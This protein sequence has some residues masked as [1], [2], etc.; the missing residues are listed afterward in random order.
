MDAHDSRADKNTTV[1]IIGA[2]LVDTGNGGRLYRCLE[3]L[4]GL[5]EAEVYL[6]GPELQFEGDQC[7]KGRLEEY[8]A[9]REGRYPDVA[10]IFQPGFEEH[11]Q[12]LESGDI[13]TLL[14][15]G[16]RVIGSS[17]SE[18]EYLRDRLMARAYGYELSPASDNPYALDP[19][20]TGLHWGDRMWHFQGKT[21]TD[22]FTPDLQL[23]EDVRRLSRMVAHSRLHGSGHQPAN[24]G[25]RFEA[26]DGKGGHRLMMHIMDGYYLDPSQGLIYGVQD[27][28]LLRTNVSLSKPELQRIP[29]DEDPMTLALWA[30]RIKD[31]YLMKQ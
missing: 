8:P 6:I 22:E 5:D 26:P 23:A 17:Y 19:A 27:G 25:Y 3:P 13:R 21:P 10:V 24:P 4:L 15:N 9:F 20:D 2:E 1:W 14:R 30:A 18:E 31:E 29:R 16:C 12:L 28:R 7:F 11:T